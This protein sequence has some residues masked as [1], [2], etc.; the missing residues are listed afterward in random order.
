M[1]YRSEVR[2][3][4]DKDVLLYAW[5]GPNHAVVKYHAMRAAWDYEANSQEP[6]GPIVLVFKIDD[7]GRWELVD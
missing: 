4:S 6:A 3:R 7:E 2:S 5:E 1:K